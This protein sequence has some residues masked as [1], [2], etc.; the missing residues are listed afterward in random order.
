MIPK[1]ISNNSGNHWTWR[2]RPTP[3][4][5]HNHGCHK[6]WC[7]KKCAMRKSISA[8]HQRVHWQSIWKLT[9]IPEPHQ[10]TQ[11]TNMGEGTGKWFRTTDKSI[12]LNNYQEKK[13]YLFHSPPLFATEHWNYLAVEVF[14]HLLS[15]YGIVNFN[16][17][18]VTVF[19]ICFFINHFRI[20]LLTYPPCALNLWLSWKEGECLPDRR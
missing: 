10:G 11:R 20:K 8:G 16:R 13:H 7:S 5:H 17:K 3:E 9:Q 2:Q 4:P 15:R 19:S 14:E 6:K 12:R 18:S 1:I